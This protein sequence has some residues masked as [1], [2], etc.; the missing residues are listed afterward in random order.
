MMAQ[1]MF[2]PGQTATTEAYRSNYERIFSKQKQ[3]EDE[4]EDL[5]YL[6]DTY[7]NEGRN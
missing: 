4:P 1:N 3:H 2:S 5:S 7:L 6:T